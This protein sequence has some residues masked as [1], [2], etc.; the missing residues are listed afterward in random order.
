[1]NTNIQS[2]EMV[3]VEGVGRLKPFYLAHNFIF[4]NL[5][6][7]PSVVVVIVVFQPRD[8]GKSLQLG[9]G[10]ILEE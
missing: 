10:P 3:Y 4:K 2:I 8:D 1:M 9:L 7:S 5:S 6:R